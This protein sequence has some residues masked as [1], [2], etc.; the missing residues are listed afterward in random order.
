MSGSGDEIENE[1]GN[2][3][4]SPLPTI[5]QTPVQTPEKTKDA[6]DTREKV[7]SVLNDP[8]IS[9]A[10]KKR[11]LTQIFE[12]QATSNA[13][14]SN[15]RR[16]TRDISSSSQSSV[17][18]SI[19][20]AQ[21][22][23]NIL[24][25]SDKTTQIKKTDVRT[26]LERGKTN[27]SQM[28]SVWGNKIVNWAKC[29]RDN[30]NCPCCFLC[31]LPIKSANSAMEHKIPSVPAYLNAP[32]FDRIGQDFFKMWQNYIKS[33][34]NFKKLT[35]LY[36]TI[37]CWSTDS[38]NTDLVNNIFNDIFDAAT[39]QKDPPNYNYWRELL[40]FW[41]MEFAYAHAICNSAK[42]ATF[43]CGDLTSAD[44]TLDEIKN[45]NTYKT[46]VKK[47][48]KPYKIGIK[49]RESGT[50]NM[51]THLNNT[52]NNVQQLSCA[53]SGCEYNE[54]ARGAIHI[55]NLR[56]AQVRREYERIQQNINR[57]QKWLNANINNNFRSWETKNK[58]EWSNYI[59]Y[60]NNEIPNLTAQ[61]KQLWSSQGDIADELKNELENDPATQPELVS[62]AAGGEDKTKTSGKSAGGEDK[63]EISGNVTPPPR[64]SVETNNSVSSANT[65]QS[66]PSYMGDTISSRAKRRR[67]N[68][69]KG[70]T[71]KN[72]RRTQKRITSRRRK[73]TKRLMSRR[74]KYTRKQNK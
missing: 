34:N 4:N 57:L 28:A 60:C 74:K 6:P 2:G 58:T 25:S 50:T 44:C 40:K 62:S 49:S 30:A 3:N 73:I 59:N 9:S 61:L 51:F 8:S 7:G 53:R 33:Q 52:L 17:Q 45:Y 55:L 48:I 22:L 66:N 19:T 64:A 39:L 41:M 70:G 10:T 29:S 12:S 42:S 24:K 47:V 27:E 36:N 69:K 56:Y 20:A 16:F 35:E 13:K 46:F 18:N 37:N 65:S 43:I 11:D 63:F 67:S 31:G 23:L 26:M 1:D 15:I 21:D 72:K 5:D 32:H 54:T 38:Y 68:E 14:E 71:I